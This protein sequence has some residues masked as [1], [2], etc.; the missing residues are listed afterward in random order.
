MN[1]SGILF[2]YPGQLCTAAMAK[3]S[4]NDVIFSCKIITSYLEGLGKAQG[5]ISF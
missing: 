3:S 1:I 5:Y 2:L 4:S